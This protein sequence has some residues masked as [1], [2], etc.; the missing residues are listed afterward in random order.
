MVNSP[1]FPLTHGGHRGGQ[2]AFPI[3]LVGILLRNRKRGLLLDAIDF[4]KQV[5]ARVKAKNQLPAERF[6]E[7]YRNDLLALPDSDIK[8]ARLSILNS[9]IFWRGELKRKRSKSKNKHYET[10]PIE[11]IGELI[12]KLVN[13]YLARLTLS[14]DEILKRQR[15]LAAGDSLPRDLLF[16][17]AKTLGF[18]NQT[19][20]DRIC[21]NRLSKDLKGLTEKVMDAYNEL[22]QKPLHLSLAKIFH[23]YVPLA[24]IARLAKWVNEV[25]KALGQNQ[26]KDRT[27]REY[28][29]KEII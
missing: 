1:Y 16:Q 7:Q 4:Q 2:G 9:D 13:A 12:A 23:I 3:I 20:I 22:R 28:I 10:Y 11:D 19:E 25:L 18:A 29:K 26:M 24:Q 27:L 5:L 17:D 21:Q 8:R 15:R 14:L 6:F